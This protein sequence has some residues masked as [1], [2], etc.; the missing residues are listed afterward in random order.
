MAEEWGNNLLVYL[1]DASGSPIG[2]CY[3]LKSYDQGKWDTYFFEKNLQ[4]DIVAVFAVSGI[5]LA[6]YVYDAWG[7]CTTSYFN[8]GATTA[9]QYNPFRYRGYY[10]DTETGFYYLQ[11]RY[12]DPVVGRFINADSYVSTGQGLIGYNM[13]AYC[14]NNPANR[15]DP[16]GEFFLDNN[17]F[18]DDFMLEGGGCNSGQCSLGGAYYNYA[19]AS[20]T[21]AYDANLGGYYSG[22]L[23]SG[24]TH[25]GSYFVPGAVSVTDGMATDIAPNTINGSF[26]FK[27][28]YDLKIHF[29]K[30]GQEFENLYSTPQEYL[31][32]ANYVINNGTY[33]A[34]MNGYIKFFGAKGGANYAFV[35]LT[36]NGMYITTYSLRSVDSLSRVPWI[37]P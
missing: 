36:Q 16:S 14:G 34:E 23:S 11:S 29:D 27:T 13:Y 7:N 3:R 15:I 33:V 9:A 18:L 8:G 35:G 1:Y 26:S 4:G 6:T 37:V 31:E 24:I 2:M 17:N 30:H 25:F 10:Y 12:Y 5:R 32:G 28:N 20:R 19:V 21:S 22:G